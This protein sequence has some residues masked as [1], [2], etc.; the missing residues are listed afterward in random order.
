[1]HTSLATKTMKSK[2]S[3]LATAA[4]A[5]LVSLPL[6]TIAKE[7]EHADAPKVSPA[8]ALARV[9]AGNQ[10]FVAGKL[11]HPHQDSKR[12]AGLGKGPPPFS[13]WLRTAHSRTS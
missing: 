12:R 4:A 11:Q 2:F 9:K 13:V 1:M 5:I 10:R 3:L 6:G 8:D 7:P